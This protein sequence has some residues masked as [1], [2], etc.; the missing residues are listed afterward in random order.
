M[1]AWP[2]VFAGGLLAGVS[3]I[4]L[5]TYYTAYENGNYEVTIKM[6]TAGEFWPEVLMLVVF[7]GLGIYV[8]GSA[9]QAYGAGG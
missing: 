2:I 1:K 6:D 8:T 7:L 3:A 4:L 5:W 9:L